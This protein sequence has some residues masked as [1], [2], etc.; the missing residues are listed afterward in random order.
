KFELF[1]DRRSKERAGRGEGVR[2]QA[3]RHAVVDDIEKADIAARGADFADDARLFRREIDDGLRTVFEREGQGVSRLS[4]L[5]DVEADV[6]RPLAKT[7]LAIAE[8]IVPQPP[9]PRIEAE[10]GD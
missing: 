9:E 6:D 3:R 2:D 4:R 5:Q 10:P 1:R 8:I 7:R